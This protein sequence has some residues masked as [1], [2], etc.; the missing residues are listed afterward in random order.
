MADETKTLEFKITTPVELSGAEQAAAAL[1]KQIGMAKALGK[2]YSAL[3]DQ[4]KTV[5]AS[6][7]DYNKSLEA[8]S[9]A[10]NDVIEVT[11][12]DIAA[13]EADT[14]ATEEQT[15]SKTELRESIR[16][17]GLEFPELDRLVH[18]ATSSIGIAF[19][20]V[21]AAVAI[22]RDRIKEVQSETDALEFPDV[23]QLIKPVQD[24]AAA[25]NGLADAVARANDNYNSVEQSADR[26][27]K[28][29][30]EQRALEK[31]IESAK[32]EGTNVAADEKAR[33]AEENVRANE[34]ANLDAKAKNEARASMRL[35]QASPE[36]EKMDEDALK[37]AIDETQ[38]QIDAQTAL[39]KRSQDTIQDALATKDELAHGEVGAALHSFA[40][41]AL[42]AKADIAT[43]FAAED[44]NA[45]LKFRQ[46]Q[47]KVLTDRL[48][49]LQRMQETRQGQ[50]KQRDDLRRS[51]TGDEGQAQTIRDQLGDQEQ[52][53]AAANKTEKAVQKFH[54]QTDIV[55]GHIARMGNAT[56]E[57]LKTLGGIAKNHADAI[58]RINQTLND[59]DTRIQKAQNN[60]NS[61]F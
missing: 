21:A 44:P 9:A 8:Q 2:D 48:D 13:S 16:G 10:A 47:L 37:K 51:A 60:A 53:D 19:A 55:G 50:I 20:S 59:H 40:D 43:G 52:S 25:W 30:Q 4:L 23:T 33:R 58:E 57:G 31:Q 42:D 36:T 28:K 29:I 22:W 17:L 45:V 18:V 11:K 39:V 46:D 27:I 38:K 35:P 15:L 3:S 61:L 26:A 7:D 12:E 14:A 5:R 1:E 54:A 32:G 56:A 34:A 49:S 41:V 24:V 6:I